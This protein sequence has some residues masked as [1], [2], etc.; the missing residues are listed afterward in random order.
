M[1]TENLTQTRNASLEEFDGS[2]AEA[3]A[4]VD[5]LFWVMKESVNRHNLRRER[6]PGARIYGLVVSKARRLLLAS[7]CLTLDG[8]GQEGGALLRPTLECLELLIYLN[9]DPE[10]RL[11]EAQEGRLPK[12]GLIAKRIDGTLKGL[13]DHLSKHASHISLEGDS[14]QHLL[15]DEQLRPA[16]E[17]RFSSEQFRK[18]IRDLCLFLQMISLQAVVSVDIIDAGSASDLGNHVSD[19][20][21]RMRK[22]FDLDALRGKQ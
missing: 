15:H 19:A 12:A 18:N 8:I 20:T 7:Y 10:K 2:M 17:P 5:R 1:A 4:I 21:C 13:R 6:H 3:C 11:Q 14:V 9:Q 16:A 22:F